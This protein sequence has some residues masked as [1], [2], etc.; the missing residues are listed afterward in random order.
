[1]ARGTALVSR[2]AGGGTVL[3]AGIGGIP[4]TQRQLGNSQGRAYETLADCISVLRRLFAGE[5]VTYEG[6][7]FTL[8]N[9]ALQDPPAKPVPIYTAA[10]SERA[11]RFSTRF[12]A[13]I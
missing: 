13:T 5:E 2:L 3:V 1:L 7:E 8:R 10:T 9:F 11:L 6:P 4:W 12:T